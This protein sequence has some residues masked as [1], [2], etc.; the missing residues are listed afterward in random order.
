[1][2][3]IVRSA[4]RVEFLIRA[5]IRGTGSPWRRRSEKAAGVDSDVP[6]CTA[7]RSESEHGVGG[8]ERVLSSWSSAG[9][10]KE[11]Q[12]PPLEALRWFAPGHREEALRSRGLDERAARHHGREVPDSMT[13][14]VNRINEAPVSAR[15]KSSSVR[16]ATSKGMSSL[17][18]PRS[19]NST[20]SRD[21]LT[22]RHFAAC[23][24]SG[25]RAVQP[26]S[27]SLDCQRRG[28]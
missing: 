22:A 1:M 3:L 6:A 19:L 9:G 14:K 11:P 4:R 27:A 23:S 12:Q 8:N 24:E 20:S 13:R 18:V 7:N 21:K 5:A 28:Q 10:E 17:G 15:D 2:S 16:G 25:A 26:E